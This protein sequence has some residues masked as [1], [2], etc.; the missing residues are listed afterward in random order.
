MLEEHR[1]G[2]AS[3]PLLGG[4]SEV[5]GNTGKHVVASVN[6]AAAMDAEPEIFFYDPGPDR[7]RC[8]PVYEARDVRIRDLRGREDE[9]TLDGFGFGIVGIDT[10]VSPFAAPEEVRAEYYPAVADLVLR[11]AGAREVHVFDHNFRSDLV[12]E[13]DTANANPVRLVHN[14]YS[15]KSGPQR[16][17]ELLPGRADE[18]LRRRFAFI[19]LWRPLS[20]PAEDWPLAVCAAPSIAPDD[21]A[22]LALR[23]PDRD[24]QIYLVRY[25][26]DHEWYYVSRMRP[27]EAL[28]LK[29]FDSADDGRA[30][31]APHSAFADPTCRP[32]APKRVSIEA[33][34]IAFFD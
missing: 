26:P 11:T 29:V 1:R 10:P 13:T 6:Y 22:T 8:D 34:T 25:N 2:A 7:V 16:V 18:L 21:F 20:H 5:A 24:G 32:D 17:R 30:R 23:Y 31:F 27:D 33:R 15:E 9:A 3:G 28:L 12:D 14:D 19:N 4:S